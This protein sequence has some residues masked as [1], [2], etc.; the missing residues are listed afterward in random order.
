MK[1]IVLFL[2]FCNNS[3]FRVHSEFIKLTLI[4]QDRKEHFPSIESKYNN[5]YQYT[6]CFKKALFA[7]RILKNNYNQEL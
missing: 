5:F 7:L 4:L 1:F 3:I 6:D 2:F